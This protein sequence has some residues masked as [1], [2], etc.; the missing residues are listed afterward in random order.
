MN[1]V[2]SYSLDKTGPTQIVSENSSCTSVS[3][4]CVEDSAE[5][6]PSGVED[7]HGMTSSGTEVSSEIDSGGLEN[8]G[9]L[10]VL[11]EVSTDR[12]MFTV[13][14]ESMANYCE[15][16][17]CLLTP[18]KLVM[19]A[20]NINLIYENYLEVD[21]LSFPVIVRAVIESV[22]THNITID[23]NTTKIYRENGRL[24][25]AP[26]QVLKYTE[27]PSEIMDDFDDEKEKFY[28][29]SLSIHTSKALESRIFPYNMRK[30]TKRYG[31]SLFES[32]TRIAHK[33]RLSKYSYKRMRAF[34]DDN[35]IN[36]WVVD[37]DNQIW[38][39]C[40]DKYIFKMLSDEM[41]YWHEL[42]IY[43]K[44]LTCM[45]KLIDH[46]IHDNEGIKEY[47]IVFE[48]RGTSL[49]SKFG[50]NVLIPEKIRDKQNAIIAQLA[51]YGMR[52]GD[53]HIG[54]FVIDDD[55]NVL[56]IDA[57]SMYYLQDMRAV[58]NIIATT[59]SSR[60]RVRKIKE[61]ETGTGEKP[62]FLEYLLRISTQI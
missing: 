56:A 40:D 58:E 22:K 44:G 31:G 14:S 17:N 51:S 53:S 50:L 37:G 52:F 20:K 7:S 48:K 42:F 62:E 46:W 57:E 33:V 13:Y 61:L 8:S 49:M 23:P 34:D 19:S 11:Q 55:E 26:W 9:C 5:M 30:I 41:F 15:I 1:P 32:S 24:K 36:N 54:N 2:C 21:I 3:S 27:F 59:R 16:S 45:P 47:F 35:Y 60:D 10:G 29:S 6:T 4:N 28:W 12:I 38:V 43:G 18:S 39:T 25:F